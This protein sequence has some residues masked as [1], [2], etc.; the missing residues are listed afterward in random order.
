MNIRP[1]FFQY[2][3]C[4]RHLWFFARG[5]SGGNLLR[6]VL[7][8]EH[9]AFQ[10]YPILVQNVPFSTRRS[11]KAYGKAKQAR[12]EA[13]R[14]LM[15]ARKAMGA[16]AEN[17]EPLPTALGEEGAERRVTFILRVTVDEQGQPRRT[18]VEHARSG[19]K[20]A[21]PGLD[22]QRLADFMEACISLPNHPATDNPPSDR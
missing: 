10:A 9:F 11:I 6:F 13:E 2:S 7:V 14:A 20:E 4:L 8:K 3:A 5:L 1:L 15:E 21:Y 12:A 17:T 19:K 16:E 18:E 22:L